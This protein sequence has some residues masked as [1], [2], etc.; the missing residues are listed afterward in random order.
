MKDK[1]L[2]EKLIYLDSEFISNLY[3]AEFDCSPQTQITRSEGMQASASIAFFS[4][5]GNSSESRTYGISSLEML[6]KLKERISKY[7]DFSSLNYKMDSPSSYCW[8]KGF[9]GIS[10]ITVTRSTHTVTL[11]GR[12]TTPN[13]D[14]KN[15]PIG[16]EAFFSFKS[17]EHKFALSPTDHYFT[18]GI[19]ALKG[20]THLVIDRLSIPSTALVRVFSANTAFGEWIA[21]P[22]VIYDADF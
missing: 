21:T 22:L 15:G 3:E 17:G 11:V 20:L 9:L 2:P 4:G 19:A 5:G 6:D 18:S 7:P 12:P 10:K 16:E 14:L 1:K 13:K 8:I